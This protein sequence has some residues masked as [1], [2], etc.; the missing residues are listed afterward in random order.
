MLISVV[1]K[2][3]GQINL[4]AIPVWRQDNAYGCVAAIGGILLYIKSIL[5]LKLRQEIKH[6]YSWQLIR[7]KYYYIS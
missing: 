1:A 2:Y 4:Q 5:K 3:A 6:F 7:P